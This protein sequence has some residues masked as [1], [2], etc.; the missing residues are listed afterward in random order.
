M[1]NVDLKNPV[2]LGGV[3]EIILTPYTDVAGTSLGTDSY[4]MDN[5]IADSTS[6]T[7]EENTTNAIEGETK[8][9]PIFENITLGSYTFAANSGDIQGVVLEKVFGFIKSS[10][11][12]SDIY[13]APTVYKPTWSKVEVK[14]GESGSVVCPRVKLSCRVNAS[15]LKTGITQ[16]EITGTC[17]A[18]SVGSSA[19]EKSPFYVSLPKAGGA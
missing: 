6:I 1:A 14:F 18:G 13:M 10:D 5:I 15:S 16:G 11:A 4:V 17:Y 7:Q 9:E 2:I 19:S 12:S 8:D 3:T